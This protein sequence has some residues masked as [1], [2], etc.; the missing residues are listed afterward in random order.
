MGGLGRSLV[1]PVWDLRTLSVFQKDFYHEHTEVSSMSDDDVEHFRRLKEMIVTGHG[2]PRPIVTFAQAQFPGYIM[3]VINREGFTAPTAIQSATWPIA[4]SGRD[5][6]GLAETGSGKTLA[7]ALPSI[8]HIN[9]QPLLAHGDG[10]IVLILAPTRELACQ[11]QSEYSKYGSSSR[12]KNTCIY[13]GVPRG[14]QM[15]DLRNGVEVVVATPGRLIDM[16]ES[17]AT[18]LRRVTYLVLDEAD[19]MLDMGFEPQI[20]KI[21]DQ[22]RPDRQTL[23]WSATWPHDIQ[24]L[25][26]DFLRDAVQVNIGSTEVTAN[27]MVKQ[28][29]ELCQD[30]EKE[31]KFFEFL[32]HNLDG[33][34]ILV[35]CD[36][37]RVADELTRTCRLHAFPALAIHGDKGQAERDWVLNEFRDGK[38]PIMIATDVAARGLDVKGI[39]WVFNYDFPGSI[40]DYVHRIGRTARAGATGSAFTLFTPKDFRHSRDLC[41][42]LREARQDVP[43]E[44]ESVAGSSMGMSGGHRRWGGGGGGGGGGYRGGGRSMG[45]TASNAIPVAPRR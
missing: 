20:R 4:L 35:F 21:V 11:I 36:T 34:R 38:S 12:I 18:N 26:N 30:H 29:I 22:V 37:K 14:P 43:S 44:L 15:R 19:R 31:R 32:E 3:E 45:A 28:H 33:S 7:Y 2:C 23:M 27:H 1:K 25:A 10:P 5:C 9:A 42:V 8:V 16:V 39:T 13:G 40:E 41:R 24:Q 17:S 6:I